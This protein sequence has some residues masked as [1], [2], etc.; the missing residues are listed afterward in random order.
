MKTAHGFTSTNEKR[1]ARLR[2]W[3]LSVVE[4]KPAS[5]FTLIETIIYL[6]LFGILI[7]GAVVASANLFESSGRAGT[8]AMLQEEGDF[9]EGKIDWVL[10]GAQAVTA[11]SSGVSCT[12]TCTLTT[13]KWDASG[14]NPFTVA[15]TGSN[16][17]LARS[18]GTP[19]ILNNTNTLVTAFSVNHVAASGDGVNPEGVVVAFTL[20]AST[21]NGMTI[22]RD[23]STTNYIRH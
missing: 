3:R 14:G 9:I 15:L 23:F 1:R 20:S 11:P 22:T 13:I 2:V 6:A 8:I 19:A 16:L 17:T 18:G 10:Y 5:G 12:T 7:G 21:P 4:A